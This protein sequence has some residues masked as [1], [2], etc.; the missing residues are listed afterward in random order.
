MGGFEPIF[1]ESDVA[2][3]TDHY[4]KMGFEI[5]FH[6]DTYAFAHRDRDLTIHLTKHD[7]NGNPARVRCLSTVRTLTK[8]PMSGVRLDWM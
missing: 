1:E 5:R 8:L 3:A 4:A 2:R 6:D 7:G